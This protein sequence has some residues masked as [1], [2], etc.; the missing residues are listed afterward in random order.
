M[1]LH[2]P[3]QKLNLLFVIEN[4][5]PDVLHSL[6]SEQLNNYP[7]ALKYKTKCSWISLDYI[8]IALR[9][10][11]GFSKIAKSL[12]SVTQITFSYNLKLCLTLK[13]E[14]RVLRC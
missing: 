10:R 12:N 3:T 2:R 1:N 8:I 6:S 11:C 5:S 7:T 14:T 4:E 13:C 9:G